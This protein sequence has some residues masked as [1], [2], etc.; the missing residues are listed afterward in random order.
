MSEKFPED[1]NSKETEVISS[2][3]DNTEKFELDRRSF[4]KLGAAGAVVVGA[5]S[6]TLKRPPL[7]LQTSAAS[8][9][10]DP[11]ASRTI[12]LNV[13][14]VNY[15]ISVEPRDMLVNIL[16]ENL[17]LI[18]TKRPCNRME[19]GGCTVLIDDVPVYSCTYL[20][21]R[22]E[23]HKILTA[24]GGN[25]DS[26]ASLGSSRCKPVRLLST[27]E[28][29]G[30]NSIIEEQPQSDCSRNTGWIRRGPVPM[31]DLCKCDSSGASCI[32]I[33]WRGVNRKW[34]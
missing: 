10:T 17:G 29:H 23:G 6:L 26:S 5:A 21:T 3:S 9:V 19:C 27:W 12:T 28:S 14:Q 13:N 2:N 15:T 25:V 34:V 11:F 16:R 1:E 33:S 8:S 30:G 22:A 20:A 32:E 18:A 31:R 7:A 4:M 24:E